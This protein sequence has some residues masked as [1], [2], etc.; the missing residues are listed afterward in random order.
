MVLTRNDAK[1]AFGH[2][3]DNVLG[4]ADGSPLKSALVEEGIDDVFS[5]VSLDEEAINTLRYDD[6]GTPK[7]LR[8]SD[9]MLLKCFL[10]FVV[11]FL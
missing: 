6:N 3:L 9:K 2:V 7:A 10:Q 11:A 4:R 5:L 1:T 8:L